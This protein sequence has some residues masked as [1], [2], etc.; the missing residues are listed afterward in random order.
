MDGGPARSPE[1][2]LAGKGSAS[3]TAAILERRLQ[4]RKRAREDAARGLPGVDADALSTCEHA[5]L[6]AVAAE[7]ARIDELR[8]LAGAEAERLMRMLAPGPQDFTGPVQ[9]ARL[10]LK[11]AAGAAWS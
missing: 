3:L 5:I 4:V 6:A 11:Q 9:D 2:R 1:S 10:A 8:D 7:R